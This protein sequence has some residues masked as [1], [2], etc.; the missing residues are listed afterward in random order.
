MFIDQ[1]S[2]SQVMAILIECNF[3]LEDASNDEEADNLLHEHDRFLGD[4][5]AGEDSLD[6]AVVSLQKEDD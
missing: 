5:P 4:L 6:Q 1:I 2:S 3:S